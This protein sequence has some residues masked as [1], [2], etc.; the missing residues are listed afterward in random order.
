[1]PIVVADSEGANPLSVVGRSF[2]IGAPSAQPPIHSAVTL[3]PILCS[4]T[5]AA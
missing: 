1:M 2:L 4:G 5:L 3:H